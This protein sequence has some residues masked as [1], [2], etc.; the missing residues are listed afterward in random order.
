MQ[1]LKTNLLKFTKS[2]P[3]RFDKFQYDYP[4][5]GLYRGGGFDVIFLRETQDLFGILVECFGSDGTRMFLHTSNLLSEHS[6]NIRI[7][8]NYSIFKNAVCYYLKITYGFYTVYSEWFQF[9]ERD[10]GESINAFRFFDNTNDVDMFCYDNR[11]RRIFRIFECLTGR[12]GTHATDI[13]DEN[14]EL[15]NGGIVPIN[16]TV[17]DTVSVVLGEG[18]PLSLENANSVARWLRCRFIESDVF[19]G[20]M[21]QVRVKGP[22]EI[23]PIGRD[24]AVINVTFV[25]DETLLDERKNR[26]TPP[27]NLHTTDFPKIYPFPQPPEISPHVMQYYTDAYDENFYL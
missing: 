27:V 15:S 25:N 16:R 24:R 10:V 19:Y 23:V 5:P 22:P 12:G 26:I 4:A 11:G 17:S 1:F 2:E 18:R 13:I 3:E 8:G 6:V 21:K 9:F 14:F 7:N 20:Q